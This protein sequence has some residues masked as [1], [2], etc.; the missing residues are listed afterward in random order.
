MT[1]RLV[2][3]V[4]LDGDQAKQELREVKSAQD[5]VTKSTGAMGAA[6]QKTASDNRRLRT[7]VRN[8]TGAAK[9]LGIA[10]KSAGTAV[11]YLGD[12]QQLAAQ[13]A[14]QFGAA[15]SGAAGQT[16]NLIAQFNDIG[17]MMA[18][19]QNP[20]QLAIQQGT[21]IT[22]V[23]GPMGASGAVKSLSTAF[24]GMLAPINLIT[25][26]AIA[27]GAAMVQWF[28]GASED[29]ATLED[30]LEDAE[31]AIQRFADA[32]ERAAASGKEMFEE[33][34]VSDPVLRQVLADM[35]AL[36]KIDAYRAIDQVAASIRNMVLELSFWDDRSSRAA[37]QDFL[38]LG[39]IG[40]QNRVAGEQFARNLE[41]LR[42]S[43]EPAERLKAALDLRQQLLNT[44]G[45]LASLNAE[46]TAFYNSLAV[47]IRDLK[48]LEATNTKASPEIAAHRQYYQSRMAA[49]RFLA[50]QKERERQKIA[51]IYRLYGQTRQEAEQSARITQAQLQTEQRRASI[52]QAELQYGRQS[53]Q[54]MEARHAA[55]REELEIRIQAEVKSQELAEAMRENLRLAQEFEKTNLAGPISGAEA[56]AVRLASKLGI[57]L[58]TARKLANSGYGQTKHDGN[59]HSGFETDDPRAPQNKGKPRWTGGYSTTYTPPGQR[60]KRKPSG[61]GGG[62]R[63]IEREREAI[64]QLLED[65]RRQI[66]IL[67]ETDPVQK[68][69]IRYRE[70][71]ANATDAERE[72]LRKLIEERLKEEQA[73]AR[74]TETTDWLKQT[75][76]DAFD[77]LSTQGR[78]ASEVWD[79]VAQSIMRAVLQAALLGEGPLAGIFGGGIVNIFG[80]I[81]LADG[82]QVPAHS[83]GVQHI[84]SQPIRLAGGGRVWGEGGSREDKVPALL[85]PDEHVINA[86]AAR[87]YRPLL[88]AINSGVALPAL[89]DGGTLSQAAPSKPGALP[90]L[91]EAG[92][93][94]VEIVPSPLF[95]AV[96]QE[97]SENAAVEVV[98]NYDREVAPETIKRTLEDDRRIG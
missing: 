67:R 31:A 94:R 20:L 44:A 38:G 75:T 14:R 19:G 82:G 16:G 79:Q 77:A 74:T 26:G 47:M 8:G 36:A 21:Q 73:V 53:A 24:L 29:A 90:G 52:L 60:T 15:Q 64:R 63:A 37:S 10:S 45:G 93:A 61:G 78:S 32:S 89:A 28:T 13:D 9:Q 70:Q 27:A 81:G 62:V 33:F 34:G 41:L 92:H 18:A 48:R 85:S 51:Q 56:A 3:E 7:E 23:I 55:Q 86:R 83:A 76:L 25:I 72:A 95:R 98:E 12:Q 57:A 17:V 80:G 88:E 39:S 6:S 4:R 68:E 35:A 2:G 87:R 71:M 22:Q 42:Q 5:Q 49:E 30:H 11:S 43:A 91:G 65:Q 46:Q 58:E 54:A 84:V 96:V 59:T 50:N 1:L 97:A 69:M 66:E 40:R